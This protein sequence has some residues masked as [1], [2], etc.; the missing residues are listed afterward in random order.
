MKKY[1][2]P[3]VKVNVCWETKTEKKCATLDKDKAYA[4]KEWVENEGGFVYWFQ[5]ISG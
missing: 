5:P 4:T 2:E 1:K 3:R